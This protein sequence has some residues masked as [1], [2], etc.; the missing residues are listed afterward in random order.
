MESKVSKS[1]ASIK[2][3]E[4]AETIRR[5][6]L[7]GTMGLG[8]WAAVDAAKYGDHPDKKDLVEKAKAA[9]AASGVPENWILVRK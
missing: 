5:R 6:I 4:K 8:Y 3:Y 7:S 9:K 2:S 1:L